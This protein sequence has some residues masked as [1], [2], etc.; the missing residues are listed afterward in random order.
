MRFLRLA[1]VVLLPF[2]FVGSLGCIKRK[3]PIPNLELVVNSGIRDVV[4]LGD[5]EGL[6]EQHVV[7]VLHKPPVHEDPAAEQLGCDLIFEM[8][9]I[10]ARAYFRRGKV[11][12]IRIQTPFHGTIR[13]GKLKA[14]TIAPAPPKEGWDDYLMHEFGQPLLHASGGTFGSEALFYSWGD[15]SYN[16]SG[17]NEIAIYATPDISAYRQRNFGRDMRLFKN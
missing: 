15:I 3:P 6:V 17:P 11:A 14:F 8:D 2:L 4:R 13:G 10:G 5:S 16:R 9:D 7:G 1:A 12:L